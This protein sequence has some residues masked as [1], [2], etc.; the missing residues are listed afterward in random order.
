MGRHPPLYSA[1]SAFIT[2]QESYKSTSKRGAY[3]TNHLPTTFE[4]NGTKMFV[5]N[6]LFLAA[7]LDH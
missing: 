7:T 6:G 5:V 2:V 1:A 3:K 4:I